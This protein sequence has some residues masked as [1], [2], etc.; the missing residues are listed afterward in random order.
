VTVPVLEPEHPAAA[1]R[2]VPVRESA[3]VNALVFWPTVVGVLLA[4]VLTKAIAVYALQPRGF[5]HP[6]VGE[7]VR[8]T[9]VYNPGAAFG[10]SVGAWSRGF[11]IA[12]TCVAVPVLWRLYRATRPFDNARTFALS[13]VMAGALGNVIDR[14]RSAD[15]VVDFID[16]G[17][18]AW[19][20]PTF[21]VADIAVTGGAL[22][23]AVVLWRED[24]EAAAAERVPDA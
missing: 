3:N 22:L 6:L 11:F 7:W 9:L 14:L 16:I 20:W 23:L 10:L 19:R 13:L 21:N 4:D 24:G 8:L 5:P 2:A 12:L 1:G 17:V 18:G 15:G